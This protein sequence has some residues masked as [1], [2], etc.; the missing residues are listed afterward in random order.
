[1]EIYVLTGPTAVGKTAAA[2]SLAERLDAEIVSC[3][4]VGVYRGMNI[5]SAKA[6]A[7]DR[8]R[9]RHHGIDVVRVGESFSVGDFEEFAV[10]AVSEIEGR[11][12]GVL[13]TGGSGF[14]LKV[15]FSAVTDGIE[16]SEVVR[17]EVREQVEREGLA[18]VIKRLGE[19]NPVGL[20]GI[21]LQNPRRV[22]RALE[23]C[24]ETGRS[25]QELEGAF[26]K[27]KGHFAAYRKRVACLMRSRADLRM[28]VERRTRR[29]LDGGLLEE[30]RRLMKEGLL[31]NRSASRAIGYREAIAYLRRGEGERMALEEEINRHTMQLAKKQVTWIR[32]QIAVDTTILLGPEEEADTSDL[33]L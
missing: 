18:C 30:V 23:R 8:W 12:K 14:Y 28:R 4:S 21:D 33:F 3:D 2:V 13:V 11:G 20:A 17:E 32:N 22:C 24:L 6:S 10:R 15:F 7:R 1:M 26:A 5:G 16:V 31:D 27:R 29:M 25:L 19:L 9:V